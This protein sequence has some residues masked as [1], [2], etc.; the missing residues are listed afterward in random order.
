MKA[1]APAANPVL[2]ELVDGQPTTTSL[3]VAAHFGKRHD[4]VLRAIRTLD[5][6]PEFNA[7]NFAEVEYLDA[8]GEQRPQYRMTRDGF[9]F[10]CM[11]FTG[12]E[13]A[14]WKEAYINAFNEM[15][16]VLKEGAVANP[17]TVATSAEPIHLSYNDRPFRIVPEGAALWFVAVD[18]ARALDM[19]DAHGLTRHLRSEHKVQRQVGHRRLGLIDRAGLELALHHASPARAEAL[20]LWLEA[21]LE[22]FVTGEAPAHALLGGLS[23]EQQ[24]A[25]RAL[26]R[27]RTAALP[28]GRR[29]AATL[30]CWS[31][32]RS[33]F[34][35]GYREIDPARFDEALGLVA[36]CVLEGELLEPEAPEAPKGVGRL[37]IDYPIEDWKAR[38]P[39]QF[40][41]DNP[42]SPELS[43]TTGDLLMS[44]YSPGEALLAQLAEAGYRV[45]GPLYELRA[46][47][48]LARRL[49]MTMRFMAGHVR[50]ALDNFEHDH[51]RVERFTGAK[52]P[53]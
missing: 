15:E 39:H 14:K 19:R 52:T 5:C 8:K 21:A 43:V 40:R 38:N 46:L 18:V 24:G 20:G 1:I 31:A 41:H 25:L 17:G 12:K 16:R 33:E 44:E 50:Q 10:L 2:V 51:R 7:R 35:C 11:G 53:R 48:S 6:S 3:D 13:A 29:K 32:L 9:T 45:D 30:R 34:G 42:N 37:G 49:D 22:Q 28:S 4:T 26:V 47:R 23:G 27:A 36:G